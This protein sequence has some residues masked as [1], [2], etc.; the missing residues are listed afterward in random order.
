MRGS[1]PFR[2]QDPDLA[3]ILWVKECESWTL[4]KEARKSPKIQFN[5]QAFCSQDSL[6]IK[7]IELPKV[8]S[9]QIRYHTHTIY[10]TVKSKFKFKE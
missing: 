5:T 6:I 4:V 1:G 9:R 2:G 7:F 10:L 8:C 3:N